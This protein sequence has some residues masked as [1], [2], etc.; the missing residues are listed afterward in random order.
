MKELLF[1]ITELSLE[2][3]ILET[4]VNDF[5]E[6]INAAIEEN[7]RVALDQVEYEKRYNGLVKQ[8]EDANAK[9]EAVKDEILKRNVKRENIERFI[10]EIKKVGM[11]TEYNEEQFQNLVECITVGQ[12]DVIVRFKDGSEVSV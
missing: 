8:F 1:G 6:T 11:V 5:A 3:E 4:Q 12:E 7:A 2:Q 10:S 9:L